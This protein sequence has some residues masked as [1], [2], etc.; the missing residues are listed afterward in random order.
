[1]KTTVVVLNYNGEEYLRNLLLALAKEECYVLVVDN[2]SKDKSKKIFNKAVGKNASFKWFGLNKNYGFAKG[3]N[4][5]GTMVRTPK[6]LFMNNDILPKKGFLKHMEDA[7]YPIVGAKLI[8]GAEKQI[9][10]KTA[11]EDFL[12]ETHKGK[13]Q[14]AGIDFYPGKGM[15][16]EIGRNMDITDGRTTRSGEVPAVTAACLLIDT[17]LFVRLN[18]FDTNFING[19]E[20]TDLCLRALEKGKKC[21]YEAKAEVIHYMSSSEGRFDNESKNKN[22]WARIWHKDNRLRKI[23]S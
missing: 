19:W 3:N 2:D 21:W 13:V 5:G 7:D 1:M 22:L 6:I 23:C 18:G 8:F 17:D 16:Y 12:V 15:P 11:N 14:H 10:V 4:I 9:K 20:D